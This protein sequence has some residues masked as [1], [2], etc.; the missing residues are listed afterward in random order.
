[1][2]LRNLFWY[3]IYE[4]NRPVDQSKVTPETQTQ[5]IKNQEDD[6]ESNKNNN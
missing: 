3:F 1:M 4:I 5:K 6:K 2:I